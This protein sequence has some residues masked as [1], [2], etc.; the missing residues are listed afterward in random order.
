MWE[1][2]NLKNYGW[3]FVNTVHQVYPTIPN[4]PQ[5]KEMQE[6]KRLSE[7]ALQIAEKKKRKERERGR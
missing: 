6:G 4:H 1:T 5:E 3:R 7:E 2:K